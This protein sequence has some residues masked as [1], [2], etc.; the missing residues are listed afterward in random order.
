[1]L[2]WHYRSKHQS[3][4][5]VS[6]Q[7]FYE[8]RLFIVPSPYDQVAGM[9]LRFHYL[10]QTAYERGGTRTN[11]LEAKLVAEAVLHHARNSPDQSLGVATFSASQRQAILKELELLRRANPDVEE[12]FGKASH[13]PFFVKNLENVQGDER[14][15]I[16]V[17]VGYGK[18]NEGYLSHSFGPLNGEGGERRLNVLI[19]RAKLRCEVFANFKGGEVDLERTRAK[20]VIALKM[21][22][23]FAETG[24]FNLG[25]VSG[26][27]YESEFEAQVAAKLA[28]L[29]HD[30]KAQIGTAGFF[31]DLAIGDPEQPGRFILGIEC[32]GEQYHSSRSARDR[33]RLRQLVLEANGWI[34]HRIWSADWYMRPEEEL[35]K[36]ESAITTARAE[37]RA[38]DDTGTVG[39]Q[40]VSPSSEVIP[41]D[42]YQNDVTA[43]VGNQGV[44]EVATCTPYHEAAFAVDRSR[45]PHEAP[46]GEMVGYLVKVVE[47]EG[48]IHIDEIATRIRSLWGLQRA[49][50][51]IRAAIQLAAASALR[52]G[53]VTGDEFL[54]LP[55]QAVV[56]R[57]RTWVTSTTLRKPEYLPPRE[58]EAAL[59]KVVGDNFGAAPDQLATDGEDTWLPIHEL[60]VTGSS[61]CRYASAS[62]ER[63]ASLPQRPLCPRHL[64]SEWL[65]SKQRK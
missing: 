26:R 64:K 56:P 30:V 1:M 5:A 37:W 51:R 11:P 53:L 33:D 46:V 57:N 63:E 14:D 38:R 55:G 17:S 47:A 36:L 10:P 12:F 15:V 44:A 59:L 25:E 20:G 65:K 40:H 31:V 22:M 6:N 41:G 52:K 7:Q 45:E 8:N 61:R 16:F 18:T 21:F 3:L 19:S 39:H 27:D 32:G 23:I 29:G 34:I 50:S 42:D 35:R 9:G 62:Y 48:P 58:V 2:N 43:A 49:G 28:S 13:V 24:K 54:S 60:S 4:I